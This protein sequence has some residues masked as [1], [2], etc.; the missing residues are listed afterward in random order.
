MPD[1]AGGRW[2]G[3]E[4]G[5]RLVLDE[6]VPRLPAPDDRMVR[7]RWRVRLRRRR[8]IMAA[9]GL[10]ALAVAAL[11]FTAGT[12]GPASSG[13]DWTHTVPAASPSPVATLMD[14]SRPLRIALPDGWRTL[15]ATDAHGTS[16]GFAAT[17]FLPG[18]TPAQCVTAQDDL[19]THCRPLRTLEAGGVLMAFR[20]GDGAARWTAPEAPLRVGAA[21][22]PA[23]GCAALGADQE[24]SGWVRA[25][26]D[27]RGRVY[28]VRVMACLKQPTKRTAAT[29]RDILTRTFGPARK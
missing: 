6:G 2:D 5:L 23:E 4:A 18:P 29:V 17:Q 28:D 3:T 15:S 19:L 1:T 26:P 24:I 27:P 22:S 21:H 7:V 8:R 9:G 14:R 13:S 11:A 12:G 20:Y 16:V 25:R 10:A